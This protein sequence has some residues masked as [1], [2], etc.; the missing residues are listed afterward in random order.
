MEPTNLVKQLYNIVK[1]SLEMHL[2]SNAV[3]FGEKLIIE[4][5]KTETYK[6]FLSKAY[7]GKAI[8]NFRRRKVPQSF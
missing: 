2:Y 4:D 6:Y 8:L 1:E 5:N 7:I 3:F